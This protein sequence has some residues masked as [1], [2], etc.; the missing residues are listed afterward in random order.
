MSTLYVVG[1]G[2]FPLDSLLITFVTGQEILLSELHVSGG[3][4]Q[5]PPVQ[6]LDPPGN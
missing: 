1:P 5:E 2:L 6:P 3:G 4:G